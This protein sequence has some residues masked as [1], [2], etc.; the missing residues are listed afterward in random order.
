MSAAALQRDFL[1]HYGRPAE[2]ISRAPGRVNLI[3]EHVDYNG[4]FVLPIATRQSTWVAAARRVPHS[5]AGAEIRVWSQA[6][7][8]GVAW[9]LGHWQGQQQPAWSRY[10]AGVA[11][12]LAARAPH[13]GGVDLLIESDVPLGGGLSSS[14]ALT[15]AVA[16]A[17]APLWDAELGLAETAALCRSAE[18]QYAGVPCGVM[19]QYASLACQEGAAL[20][21]DCRSLAWE[22]VPLPLTDHV[23]MVVDSGVRH[24]LASSAYAQRQ[25]ECAAAVAFFQQRDPNVR[26]LRD[27]TPEQVD[28]VQ[29]QMPPLAARRARHVTREI[30]RTCAAAEALRRSD[31]G[32]FGRLMQAS[33]V[34]LRDDYEVSSPEL[35]QLVEIAMH[36][37][38]VLGARMTGGGF[39]GCVVALVQES[40]AAALE[41]AVHQHYDVEARR[42]GVLRVSPGPGA[43]LVSG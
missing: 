41:D 17:L 25:Q 40:R 39:G 30:R 13:P 11:E 15:V 26:A 7:Q 32:Q 31:L 22:R 42:A 1:Q 2:R 37:E 10:V 14:A 12:L 21:L 34:S 16:T 6:K 4:G 29:A 5:T 28:A 24:E 36:V 8:A 3:G 20:L 19:D 18:H 9:R 43:E 27:V 38:G 23:L 35:D 33:H